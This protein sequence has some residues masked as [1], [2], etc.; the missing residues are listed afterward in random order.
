MWE[1]YPHQDRPFTDEGYEAFQT[2]VTDLIN[3]NKRHIPSKYYAPGNELDWAS[4][5]YDI[6]KTLYDGLTENEEVPQDYLDSSIPIAEAQLIKGGYRL[7]FVLDYVF[8]S[9]NDVAQDDEYLATKLADL[10]SH[11]IQ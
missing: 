3:R 6:A 2:K 1:G 4:D 5:S 11:L 8:S 7:A 9:S 10:L